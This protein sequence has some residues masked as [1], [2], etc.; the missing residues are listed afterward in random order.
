MKQN[1]TPRNFTHT[2]VIKKV[3]TTNIGSLHLENGKEIN[4]ESEKAEVRNDYFA[5]VF[6]IEDT[7]EIQEVTPAKPNSIPLSDCHFTEDTATKALDKIKV[8]KTP[9]PDC[10]APRILKEAT[11]Q[12]SKPLQYYSINL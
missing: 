8:N 4:T 3:I 7:Y 5:S 6:T 2:Y 9:D 11:Y 1:P 12:I 10:I